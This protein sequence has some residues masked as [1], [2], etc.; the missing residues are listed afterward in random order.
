ML[1]IIVGYRGGVEWVDKSIASVYN[2]CRRSSV[3]WALKPLDT[4]SVR[5]MYSSGWS[6]LADHA[7][8]LAGN[9]VTGF[10]WV[11]RD[12]SFSCRVFL[13]TDISMPTWVSLE[14][15]TMLL[16]WARYSC[17]KQGARGI[18]CIDGWSLYSGMY[19]HL[20]KLL[21]DSIVEDYTA[22]LMVYK[23]SPGKYFVPRNYYVRKATRRDIPYITGVYNKAFSI[24]SW[25]KPS[26]T[27]DKEWFFEKKKPL[28]L[29]VVDRENRVVGYSV[30]L[31]YKAFD[32]RLTAV[33][34]TVAVDPC[35]Q[36]RGLG[37]A[38]VSRTIEELT[39]RGVRRIYLDSVKGLEKLYS[40]LGFIEYTRWMVFY[41]PLDS[42]PSKYT[43]FYKL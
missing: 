3:A 32:N 39:R 1:R 26:S 27:S 22:T 8:V 43:G 38:L 7:L 2:V 20:R 16:S 28:A 13:C 11:Y 5:D 17:L 25:F 24:Y 4:G 41:T 6:R 37:S 19:N 36:K 9:R 42:L 12:N 30:A 33:I 18:A 34:D 21:G 10:A 29:V 15:T 31:V 35:H 23:G 40:R 14:S